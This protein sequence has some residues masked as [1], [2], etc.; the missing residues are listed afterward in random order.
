MLLTRTA[1]AVTVTKQKER[2]SGITNV[3][4]VVST[5]E[6]FLSP[7]ETVVIISRREMSEYTTAVYPFPHLH[8][9]M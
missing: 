9:C 3:G 4:M 2:T 5:F 6:D 1:P 7:R 8:I